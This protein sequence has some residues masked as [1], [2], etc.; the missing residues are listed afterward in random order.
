MCDMTHLYVSDTTHSTHAL[1]M[2]HGPRHTSQNALVSVRI[3][4]FIYINIYICIYIYIYICIYMYIYICIYMYI[5]IYTHAHTE[6]D[7]D[8]D[9][10]PKML[11][12]VCVITYISIYTYICIYIHIYIYIYIYIYLYIYHK[13]NL[14]FELIYIVTL[15][16]KHVFIRMLAGGTY[17]LSSQ[18]QYV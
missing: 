17:N 9:I 14:A 7:I 10:L 8:P 5:Y 1:R 18:S 16:F 13:E 15:V 4:I 12:W 2:R 11:L 3:F 6:C